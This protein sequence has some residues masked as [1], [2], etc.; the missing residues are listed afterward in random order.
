MRKKLT[1]EEFIKKAQEIHNFEYDYSEINYINY[2]SK[3]KIKCLKHGYFW[4]NAAL[5]LKK[6]GCPICGKSK[7]K[8]NKKYN[9]EN[10][11]IK[12][13]EVHDNKYTYEKV[14]FKKIT[15]K[16]TIT[17]F[18]HGDWDC[19]ASNHLVGHDCHECS[20]IKSYE[21]KII[22]NGKIFINDAIKK[23]GAKYNYEKVI[24]KGKN[25]KVE[26]I[27]LAHGNIFLTPTAHLRSKTGGCKQCK[28]LNNKNKISSEEFFSK[29]IKIHND[30][31]DYSE[32]NFTGLQN[33]IC[34]R[35][36]EHGY[37]WQLANDHW[38]DK[39][40]PDC[41]KESRIKLKTKTQEQVI[42]DFR[43]IHEDEYDYSKVVY[44]NGYTKVLIKCKHH[45]FFEQTPEGHL[46]GRG[47]RI[48]FHAV[49][50]NQD[51]WLDYLG[52]PN[53]VKHR[54]V[55]LKIGKN[56]PIVDGLDPIKKIVYEFN[57]DY[58]HGNPKIYKPDE[59]NERSKFTFGELYR[60]T[61]DREKMLKS[62]GYT[63]ISIWESDFKAINKN[64]KIN[65]G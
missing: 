18:L 44:I 21:T 46:S 6:S 13:Q 4:Q 1:Q 62:A 20:K 56:R 2:H 52:I 22:N 14:N 31:Y 48:C 32:S 19:I 35:C 54:N 65:P 8:G 10:F 55:I 27:C 5:H 40:C 41:G 53:D 11:I 47:C 63:V 7:C 43:K 49:S 36:F 28:K 26:I 9:L 38:S 25:T 33:K 58:W 17:C 45:G 42:K 61:I 37:F 16:I 3:M 30:K 60:R 50:K 12:A 51:K 29:V 34:I 23:F 24:F 15:D 64:E 39:G 57:G 59:Y